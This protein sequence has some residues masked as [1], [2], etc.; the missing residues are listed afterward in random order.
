[1][2]IWFEKFCLAHTL[3][4]RRILLKSYV[5]SDIITRDMLEVV[6]D[7]LTFIAIMT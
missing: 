7:L 5:A 2:K 3:I 1:M 6:S 4:L